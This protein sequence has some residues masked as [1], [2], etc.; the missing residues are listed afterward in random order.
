MQVK[1][2]EIPGVAIIQLEPFRDGRGTFARTY[3]QRE[4]AKL[5]LQST[6]V[7]GNISVN[8]AKHTLRGFHYQL[9]PHGETKTMICLT[10]GLYDVVVD[11]RPDSPTFKQW[12][13]LEL[14]AENWQALVVPAGCANAFLTLSDQTIVQYYMSEFFTP[15]GYRG[16]RYDDPALKINWPV[17]PQVISDKDADLPTLEQSLLG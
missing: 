6:F 16:F 4:F 14:K 12:V 3:C 1:K 8:K 10:G 5:G 13:A 15:H 17:K 9:P 11:L 2:L 7:Q